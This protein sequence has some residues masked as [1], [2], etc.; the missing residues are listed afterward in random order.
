MQNMKI[1]GAGGEMYCDEE[2]YDDDTESE[3]DDN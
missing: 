2:Y 3:Y 1:E